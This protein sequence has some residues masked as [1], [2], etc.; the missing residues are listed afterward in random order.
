MEL[1]DLIN[2]LDTTL[3]L[4]AFPGDHS[5]N[6]LQVEG[7]NQIHK[8][9]FAVDGANQ[10]FEYA[11]QRKAD[12]I[13]VHHGLS[14]GSEPRRLIGV[15]AKRFRTLFCNNLNLYAAHLPLDAHPQFGNN[16]ALCDLLGLS[17]R[18]PFFHYEGVDIGF[19]GTLPEKR[20]FEEL[21]NEIGAKLKTKPLFAGLKEKLISKVAVVSGGG[22]LEAV[23]AAKACQAEALITGELTHVMSHYISEAEIG[24]IALGHY[25]SETTGVLALMEIV[26]E[27]FDIECEFADFPTGL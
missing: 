21:G 7:T 15:D 13:F 18:Q 1:Q 11:A 20:T 24:V 3:R 23:A 14:W 26:K 27:K 25:A 5:N 22:G 16:A 10:V 19:L 4:S 2:F 17:N 9:I 12:F 8:I 6:G